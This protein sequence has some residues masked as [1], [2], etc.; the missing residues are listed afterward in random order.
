MK[1]KLIDPCSLRMEVEIV[2]D[3]TVRDA[4]PTDSGAYITAREYGNK[5]KVEV[6]DAENKSWFNRGVFVEAE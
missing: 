2:A 1:V 6:Y 3:L 5:V 4:K